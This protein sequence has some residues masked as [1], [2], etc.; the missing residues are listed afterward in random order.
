MRK[1]LKPEARKRQKMTCLF[2]DD[3][4]QAIRAKADAAHV[5]PAALGRQLILKSLGVVQTNWI[6]G[7]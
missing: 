3:E 2:K 6:K 5:A 4:F 1:K 7:D